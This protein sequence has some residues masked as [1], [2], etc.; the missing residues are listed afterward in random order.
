MYRQCNNLKETGTSK[1]KTEEVVPVSLGLFTYCA[2]WRS[3]VVQVCVNI[4]S[5]FY[6]QYSLISVVFFIFTFR[7]YES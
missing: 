1:T 2:S 3:L 7:H 5:I 6:N 4:K